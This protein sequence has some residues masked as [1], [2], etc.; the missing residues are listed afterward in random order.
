MF[1]PLPSP[2]KFM[3]AKSR[4]P[5]KTDDLGTSQLNSPS[6]LLFSQVPRPSCEPSE[7]ENLTNVTPT[8]HSQTRS[9][10]L[11]AHLLE[12]KSDSREKEG[13]N[14]Q[15]DAGRA[16]LRWAFI[17]HRFHKALASSMCICNA[18]GWNT[19]YAASCCCTMSVSEIQCKYAFK[20][21]GRFFP[22]DESP[23]WA[24]QLA[25]TALYIALWCDPFGNT[26]MPVWSFWHCKYAICI[27]VSPAN[28]S[29]SRAA[30][31]QLAFHFKA[32]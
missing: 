17:Q 19:N 26:N 11:L 27:R 32:A 21:V 4:V 3:A 25:F 13:C 20:T 10:G 9:L 18:S 29:S 2:L 23:S 15:R 12:A 6:L 30:T 8:R 22:A 16:H 24:L 1:L 28:E 5:Y 31:L 14:V 7:L